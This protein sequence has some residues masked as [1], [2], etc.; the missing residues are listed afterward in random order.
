MQGTAAADA[1]HRLVE[2]ATAKAGLIWITVPGGRPRAAWHHWHGG[3]TH[4]VTGGVEQ[5][6]PGLA[7]AA[8]CEV[9]VPSKDTGGRLV[10]WTASVSRVQPDSELWLQVVP[11]MHAKRLNPADGDQQP[12]RWAADCTVLRLEPSGQITAAPGSLPQDAGAAAPVQTPATT[13]GPLPYVLGRRL[14]R[15][16]PRRADR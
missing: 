9:T 5:P 3:A 14:W 1:G 15:R 10:T 2:E 16:R 12:L 6:L 8:V 4:V 13:S 7:D 11:P